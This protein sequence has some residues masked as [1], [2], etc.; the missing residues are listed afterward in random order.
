MS[1]EINMALTL[2]NPFVKEPSYY[3]RKV[4]ILKGYKI[5]S[6]TYLHSKHPQ[7][8]LDYCLNYVS[9]QMKA[10]GTN[11]LKD[12]RVM[13]ISQ[14]KRGNRAKEVSTLSSLLNEVVNDQNLIFSPSM[15]AYQRP[16]IVK[17]LLSE[18][19][20]GNVRKRKDYKNLK[21][22]YEREGNQTLKAFYDILQTSV[23]E[24]NNSLS[25]AG[26]SKYNAIYCKSSHL[27][28]TSGC[29]TAT[30]YANAS[31]ER[32]IAGNRH[33]HKVNVVI[34]ELSNANIYGPHKEIAAVLDKYDLAYPSVEQTME[35]ILKSSRKYWQDV[36]SEAF[37]EDYVKTLSPVARA[38]FCYTGDAYHLSKFNPGFV[39]NM[40]EQFAGVD[41]VYTSDEFHNDDVIS[42]M[43]GD[44]QVT[45]SLL[46][47]QLL[48][49]DKKLN[50]LSE[51]HP[52][53]YQQVNTTAYNFEC[54]IHDYADLIDALWRPRY[55]ISSIGKF[56][57]IMREAVLT[58][59]TDSTI[60]TTMY[61]TEKVTGK[62]DFSK[63]SYNIGY[64][65]V[66]FASQIVSNALSILCAN[67]G[68]GV[69]QL[70]MLQMKNE[71]YFPIYALTNISKHY[72]ALRSAQ[73][74]VIKAEILPDGSVVEKPELEMK[75]VHLISS[76]ASVNFMLR[77]QDY[78]ENHTFGQMLQDKKLSWYEIMER[79]ITQELDIRHNIRSGGVEYY[80]REQIKDPR[81]YKQG[82]DNS[83]Y[84]Q[85]LLWSEVFAPKYGD[86]DNPPL[87]AVKIP[88]DLSKP[89]K[90]KTWIT[91][92][93]TMDSALGNRLEAF[94]ESKDKSQF[95]SILIPQQ[96]IDTT[97]LPA[98]L[99]PVIDEARAVNQIMTPYYIAL[100]SFGYYVGNSKNTRL[101]TDPYIKNYMRDQ[102]LDLQQAA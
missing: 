31:N 21:F 82:E 40:F 80:S 55:L 28:L 27:S 45:V 88:V 79:P 15:I 61:W 41:R 11:E 46:K 54:K 101:L 89:R 87:Y 12:P 74:G 71:Y 63:E 32:Y 7:F 68:I 42:G 99:L 84:F 96:I 30:S 77:F 19:L 8:S 47:S 57:S 72:F 67:M 91:Q 9:D 4:D 22:K 81:D 53:I 10:G 2:I 76:K 83:N 16:E 56:R 98:E 36:K 24:L 1:Q 90:L 38:A 94:L 18:F 20:F 70:T 78:V 64:L 43:D 17:S 37:I 97:G 39:E 26:V 3:K 25:G 52:D 14:R 100:Q 95:T 58:S 48:V 102:T 13:F 51:T 73:E 34:Q 59:D 93:K 75:G 50:T 69:E 44:K 66:Y 33:Y 29:R 5:A 65:V 6:A 49:G 60:F 23:K 85:Y 35:C 92:V 62:L 86:V